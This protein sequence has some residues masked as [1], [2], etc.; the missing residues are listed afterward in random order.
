MSSSSNENQR[1]S[2]T[3]PS[4]EGYNAEGY[5]AEGYNVRGYDVDGYNRTGFDSNGQDANGYTLD[6]Q[7]AY[8]AYY[9][10]HTEYDPTQPILHADTNWGTV[11]ETNNYLTSSNTVSQGPLY[12][13][14]FNLRWTE[15]NNFLPSPC[16]YSEEQQQKLFLSVASL[17]VDTVTHRT[18]C[19]R[20]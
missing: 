5:N 13:G 9:T 16:A 17:A 15:F 20:L 7:Q 10:V 4:A 11:I 2:L 8:R 14:D 6:Q 19:G 18:K 1:P 3:V 12:L